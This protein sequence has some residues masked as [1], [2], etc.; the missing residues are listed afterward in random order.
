MEKLRARRNSLPIIMHLLAWLVLIILPQIIISRYSGN[1]SFIAWGFY[2]NAFIIGVIFYIN[3]FWLVPK[4]YLNNKKAL[5]FLLAIVV[6]ICFYFVLDYSNHIFHSPDRDRRIAESIEE[7]ARNEQR[8]QRPP[9]KLMQIYG[10]TLLSI[11][12]VGFSIGLRAIEQYTASEKRQKELEKEKLNSELAFLKNQVSPHFFFNTLNNIYSMVAINTDD[13]QAAILK[14]SKLM[15]YL[16]YESEHG[17]TLLS[18]EV[19]FMHHYIDLMQLRVSQKVDIHIDLPGKQNDLKI[20]PL[21]FIPFI[22]N[23]FKHGISYREKSFIK[24]KMETSDNKVFFS[25]E[26]SVAKEKA[27]KRD[28]NHSGIGLEN[29][30]KRLNLLF[31]GKYDLNIDSSSEVFSVKLEIDTTK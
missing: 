15:R 21:L 25:C 23:A 17:E 29:V 6:V 2:V 18:A 3:Y 26:N 4:F 22:E 20:P 10:F 16:L 28:E 11:V 12:I 30:K 7:Q 31:D 8:F 5:F 19:E 24:V 14:L 9:F 27:E 13:A 1:N